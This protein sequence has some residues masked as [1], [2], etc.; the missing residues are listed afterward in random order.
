MSE[1]VDNLKAEHVNITSILASV[2]EL[3]PH[4]KE[5][6]QRLMAA[7]M[8]LILHLKREDTDLY[9][10]LIT[11]A[12]DDPEFQEILCSFEEEIQAVTAQ[13]LAFFEKH[14]S[15]SN[16]RHFTEDFNK[17]LHVLTQRIEKEESVIYEYYNK[18]ID[19]N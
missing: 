12:E 14:E 7:K 5:G 15:Q 11:A 16:E 10:I 4:T 3:G 18:F 9:P 13:A 2:V 6:Y 8:S 1:L 17:L 19:A